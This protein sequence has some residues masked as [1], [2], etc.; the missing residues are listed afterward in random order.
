VKSAKVKNN[1][2]I[3]FAGG[4]VATIV[5]RLELRGNPFEHY[6]AETEPDIEK[7]AIR[8][9]YLQAISAR[10]A[11]ASSFILFGDRGSGKSATRITVYGEAWS[12][13]AEGG[14]RP[15]VVN[16]SEFS[17]LQAPLKAG[18]LSEFGIVA[19]VAFATIEQLLAWMAS[20]EESDR[21]V[22]LE[23]LNSSERT[24]IYAL[25]QAFYF[26]VPELDREV[27]TGE[28]LKLLNT[29]WTTQS[30]IWIGK[31]WDAL[32][33]IVSATVAALARK[34]LDASVDI[35]K[36]AESLLLSLKGESAN[37]PRA[38]LGKLVE[39]VSIFGFSGVVALVDKVDETPNTANSAE[40]TT[41]LV[42]PLLSHVQLL[43]VPNFAWVMFLW[44]K[45][46]DHFNSE[47]YPVRLDKLAHADISWKPENLRE[48]V[49]AR[50]RFF[51]DGT[52][53]F[54]SLFSEGVNVV[55]TFDSIAR[56][57][58]NSPRELIKLMDTII[59]EHD[60][61]GDEVAGLL[62]DSTVAA[63][64]DKY[65]TETIGGVYQDKFL[66]QLLRLGL[67]TF[68][69]KDVQSAFKISDQAARSKIQKWQDNGLVRQSG[70][71][72]PTS[73]LG[74]QPAYRFVVADARVERIIE[75]K[76][77][78]TVGVQLEDSGD[79]VGE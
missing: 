18:T 11:S 60:L 31:R 50:I 58:I 34:N 8:P 48:M 38:V 72:A 69:N 41:R 26:N 9:P 25:L 1:S 6:T 57:A 56:I 70:T 45:V 4:T 68:V 79:A 35:E 28:A 12:Q 75:R 62:D 54:K 15:F 49:E 30:G 73:E 39:L 71:Q 78:D 55:D 67:V 76:L 16:F 46:K 29:A 61:R 32:A 17:A 33:R 23:G 74:G 2:E 40:A 59:R 14:S 64:Q 77:L 20:L 63:G 24:L 65:V 3:R 37:V 7:Y 47:K 21:S 13:T 10:V 42:H 27:T 22:Y 51:S 43:E 53:E 66:Q 44:G 36:A 19:S 5:E 52:H